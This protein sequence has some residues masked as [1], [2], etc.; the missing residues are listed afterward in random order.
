[1]LA[2]TDLD[3]HQARKQESTLCYE[4]LVPY[5]DPV[6]ARTRRLPGDA[7][8]SMVLEIWA[9][10]AHLARRIALE[11]WSAHRLYC[12]TPQI[13]PEGPV[14]LRIVARIQPR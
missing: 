7:R 6:E 10:S 12:R 2:T 9:P 8:L 11:R 1:M 14:L 4:V 13:A 5:T 3:V